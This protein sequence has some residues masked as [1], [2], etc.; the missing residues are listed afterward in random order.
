MRKTLAGILLCAALAVLTGCGAAAGQTAEQ[1]LCQQASGLR[2]DAAVARVDGLEITAERYLYLLAVNCDYLSDSYSG[3]G[4]TL[5]WTAP[6][7]SGQTLAGYAKQR[8]LETAAL[9]AEI[10]LLSQRHGCG[11]TAED[12]SAVAADESARA[13]QLGG[14]A[15]YARRLAWLGMSQT[16]ARQLSGDYRLY[17]HL[18]ALYTT[19]GS[20]LYPA[21]GTADAA[22]FDALLESAADSAEITYSHA[23]DTLNVADFYEKL[24]AARAAPPA[25]GQGGETAGAASASAGS[26]SQAAA[27]A[28]PSGSEAS[29]SAASAAGAVPAGSALAG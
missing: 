27:S 5:D 12:E 1:S 6:L 24:T 16:G 14:A 10:E 19:P 15:A 18:Y 3:A 4:R 17:R 13:E 23:Y 29:R 21:A 11:L 22:G 28:A 26:G 9:Y 25:A 7:G 20:A 2:P 8:A